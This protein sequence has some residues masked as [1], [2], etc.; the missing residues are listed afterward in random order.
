MK[1]FIKTILQLHKIKKIPEN[2]GRLAIL[3]TYNQKHHK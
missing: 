1:N 2:A 3:N